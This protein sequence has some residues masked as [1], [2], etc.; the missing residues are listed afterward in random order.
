MSGTAGSTSGRHTGPSDLS[1]APGTALV[2]GATGFL[3]SHVVEALLS[4]G[5]RV[6]CTVRASSNRRWID[7]LPVERL[8][9]DMRSESSLRAAVEGVDVVVHSAGVTRAP[10]E[11]TYYEVNAEGTERLAAAALDGG[12]RRVVLISSLAARGPDSTSGNGDSG[13]ER[14]TSAYGRSK[15]AGERR[16]FQAVARA[17]RRMEPV[18]LRPGGIYGPRDEDSLTL[19]RLARG[20]AIPVPATRGRL[21]PVYVQ[22]VADAVVRAATRPGLEIGPYPLLGPEILSWE[23]LRAAL[24]AAVGHPVRLVRVPVLVWQALGSMAEGA[25]RLLRVAPQFDR[26]SADD[27]AK[28]EWTS[29]LEGTVRAL[30][31][32][33]QTRASDALARTAAWYREH[34]WLRA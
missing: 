30:G 32:A 29:D 1:G 33:P 18:I 11:R 13:A 19:F 27:L 9:A 28:F 17:S 16:L 21:Q 14:P 6:R 15:L 5:W 8:T 22:D 23:D 26:R 25:A 12:V 4:E 34:G 31:W 7:S 24:Q 10:M 20:G 2:T 3:G